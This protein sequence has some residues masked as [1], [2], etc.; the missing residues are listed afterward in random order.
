VRFATFEP[1]AWRDVMAAGET[2]LGDPPGTHVVYRVVGHLQVFLHSYLPASDAAQAGGVHE[3]SL[4]GFLGLF[5]E[6]ARYALA[7]EPGVLRTD[8]APADPRDAF[9][10]AVRAQDLER[11]AELEELLRRAHAWLSVAPADRRVV[12]TLMAQMRTPESVGE[13]LLGPRNGAR[14][15]AF[16]DGFA[17]ERAARRDPDETTSWSDPKTAVAYRVRIL[18]PPAGCAFL[19][20]T[21]DLTGVVPADLGDMTHEV[22][23]QF[24]RRP[25]GEWRYGRS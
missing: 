19:A 18:D 9:A 23:A 25:D 6:L 17:R 2:E 24:C 16:L 22:K 13:I 3:A 20:I 10:R 8:G 14:L 12:R 15:G 5:D 1:R 7:S 4:R 11:R 21:T